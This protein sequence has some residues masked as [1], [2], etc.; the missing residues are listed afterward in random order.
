MLFLLKLVFAAQRNRKE[1]LLAGCV[2]STILLHL[3]FGKDGRYVVY[4]W[5]ATVLVFLFIY[6]SWLMKTLTRNSSPKIITYFIII[7]LFV[8]YNYVY[9]TIMIPVFSNNIFEQ[10]YQMHRFVTEYYKKPV[11]VNNL[12]YVAFNNDNYVLDLVGLASIEVQN[13][14]KNT[15]SPD[16]M[17]KV[18]NS[19]NVKFAMIYDKW[20][21]ELPPNWHKVAELYLS[22]IKMAP[23]ESAVAFYILDNEIVSGV[24]LQ[25]KKFKVTLPRGVK[26]IIWE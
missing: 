18:A 6:R 12:G 25:L 9:G 16:W 15:Y 23:A 13:L 1:R 14:K 20:F 11:A 7:V 19:H 4:I 24:I 21:E 2:A 10:Q 8:S 3:L 17:N 22:K 26:L 5:T